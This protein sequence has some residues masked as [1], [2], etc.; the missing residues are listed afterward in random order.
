VPGLVCDEDTGWL[1]RY[2]AVATR[3]AFLALLARCPLDGW[4]S[5]ASFVEAVREA[6]PDFQRPDG[7]YTSWYIRETASKEYLSGFESWD[8]VE[9]ALIADLLT[10]PLCWL[11]IVATATGPADPG[12]PR[13]VVCRLTEAGAR[14]LGL[15]TGELEYP[16]SPPLVVRP[17]FGIELP[18]PVN[19]YTRFQL[20]RFADLESLEPCRYHLTVGALGRALARG[21]RVEQVLAFLQQAGEAPVPANVAGQLRLWAGRFGQADVEEVALLTVKNERVLRELTVLPQ[22]R[23]LIGQVLTATTALVDKRHVPRLRQELAALGYLPIPSGEPA[24]DAAEHG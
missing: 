7:D 19:L 6:N 12:Q 13:R 23:A 9:G 16:T 3:Q 22:T 11:G 15:L 4:W 20:E 14:L 5:L 10:G 24:S 18:P 17:D 8:R 1:L 21:V 2:N